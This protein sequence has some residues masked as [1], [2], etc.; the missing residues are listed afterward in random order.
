MNNDN[1]FLTQS[2]RFSRF[3]LLQY[4]LHA[5]SLIVRG[6]LAHLAA[7]ALSIESDRCL[8]SYG[9]SP[10]QPALA[11]AFGPCSRRTLQAV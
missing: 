9:P 5:L 2:V 11:T 4:H 6:T 1:D 7:A 10:H 8:I 3:D